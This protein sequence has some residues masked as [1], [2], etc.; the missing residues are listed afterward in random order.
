MT[1]L[2]KQLEPYNAATGVLVKSTILIT[3]SLIQQK[4]NPYYY[5]YR[6]SGKRPDKRSRKIP[7]AG[8]IPSATKE[9]PIQVVPADHRTAGTTR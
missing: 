4:Y 3:F 7:G 9:P 1:A 2:E 5:R 8:D 6:G